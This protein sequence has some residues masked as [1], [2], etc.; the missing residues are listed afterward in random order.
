MKPSVV[1]NY[2]NWYW[3]TTDW[4][5]HCN[6]FQYPLQPCRV[7]QLSKNWSGPVQLTVG[8]LWIRTDARIR[9]QAQTW[10]GSCE[11]M[12]I[13]VSVRIQ[14]IQLDP[15]TQHQ[16]W[17]GSIESVWVDGSV[18]IQHPIGYGSNLKIDMSTK[19]QG[20]SFVYD[21]ALRRSG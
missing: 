8:A 17:H 13:R 15:W 5:T 19:S 9:I 4:F 11:S 10:D 21:P 12:W 18:R 1:S 16:N 7:P 6:R 2:P 20:Y 14:R 3:N